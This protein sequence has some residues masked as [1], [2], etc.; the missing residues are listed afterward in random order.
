MS[1]PRPTTGQWKAIQD[2]KRHLTVSA[3]AGAGKTWVLTERYTA[4]LAGHP[5]IQPPLELAG[6]DALATGQA[7]S[8]PGQIVAITFTKEAAGEMKARIRERLSRWKFEAAQDD[9][10]RIALLQEEVERATITT[11]HGYCA[12]LL[13]QYP[14]EA[15]IDPQARV[16]EESEA[17]FRLEEA[18]REALDE[19]LSRQDVGVIQLVNEYSYEPLV[20][21]L[22][23]FYPSLRERTEDFTGMADLTLAKLTELSSGL[24]PAV[25]QLEALIHNVLALDLDAL[26]PSKG[27]VQRALHLRA[28]WPEISRVLST[29]RANHWDFSADIP[30][31]LEG[32]T[33]G[34]GPLVN[35]LKPDVNALKAHVP[36]VYGHIVPSGLR[37]TVVHLTALLQSV[38]ELY[39]G[40]KARDRALDFT[41]LQNLAVHLLQRPEV[42]RW[43]AA[44]LRFLMVDEFQD[45]NPVQKKL[46][47]ALTAD[48]DDLRLFVVG[49]AKQSIYRFRGADLDVFLQT[50]R[51][52]GD[53]GGE[54]VP[55][56]HNFRTQKPIISFV[57]RFFEL[58]MPSYEPMEA[59]RPPAH[60]QTMVEV[61]Q[62][63]EETGALPQKLREARTV[64]Q[65][66]R[67]MVGQERLVPDQDG[68]LRTVQYRDITLLFSAMTHVYVYEHAFQA[69]G[70]PYYI[71]GSR[72]FFRRQEIFDLVSV[73]HV[74]VEEH[75]AV[76]RIGALRS[77]LFGVSDEALYWLG[78]AGLVAT[79]WTALPNWH[80][81]AVDD[82]EK[83]A[84][85][86]ALF[87][88][89]REEKTY[90]SAAGV[91]TSILHH[92]GYEQ[93]LLL[94]FG[95]DQKV[96]NVRKLLELAQQ[97]PAE[98][99]S[100]LAFLQEL[101]KR[102]DGEVREEDAQVESD[103][104]DVVKI[105]T[106]HKSKGLEFPVVILPD[107]ARTFNLSEGGKF[108]YDPQLGLVPSF[109]ENEAWNQF[110]YSTHL[111]DQN[112][113]KALEEERRKLYV[114]MTRARDYLLLVGTRA[115]DKKKTPTFDD[116]RWFD[117][118]SA[119]EVENWP[120]VN[121]VRLT[122]EPEPVEDPLVALETGA[123]EAAATLDM[124]G[125]VAPL[126]E[127]FPLLGPIQ[128]RPDEAPDLTLSVSALLTYFTCPRQYYYKYA[129]RLPELARPLEDT[130]Q[131]SL[132]EDVEERRPSDSNLSATE[133]EDADAEHD[134]TVRGTLVHRVLELLRDPADLPALLRRALAERKIV[135]E[136][137]ERWI[138]LLEGDLQRF[139][140]SEL[141]QEVQMA[142]DQQSEM[143][144]RLRV[145]RHAVTGV[146]DKLYKKPNGRAVVLDYK[147][148]RITRQHLSRTAHHYTPQLQLYTLV[149][150]QL[151]GWSVERAVLYFTALDAEAEVPVTASDLQMMQSR[152][153][154][155]CDQI[156]M[157]EGEEGY[158]QTE[159][160]GETGETGVCG[161]C[162]YQLICR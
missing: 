29:W 82:R 115:L 162:P 121:W 88:L 59:T 4:M 104:S 91:L 96:G 150:E 116:S 99:G 62:I 137:A 151:L 83:L 148:N 100:V 126:E 7:P 136:E 40:K 42:R 54:H 67:E 87:R 144:F 101:Q 58:F 129:L 51:E 24:E 48:N 66:I 146:I 102:I 78:R 155:A 47:D 140:N 56:A 122:E 28:Q 134:P 160:T 73:M 46:L 64:A 72:N 10:R 6:Q 145:G 43:Q 23:D 106:V 142:T 92:T 39:R 98:R 49:D 5:L 44:S 86:Q 15:G 2:L 123:A 108:R 93:A 33:A 19:G 12:D 37:T 131:M 20:G 118:L 30:D 3:G 152:L 127:L 34:W 55:L 161:R 130:Q 74:L 53:V 128:P 113:Q 57:N 132:F 111:S 143:M 31:V 76:A 112:K 97:Q 117:W 65:R 109:T 85:A 139:A 90:K 84:R 41:D 11:I 103:Q 80:R 114:A 141:F 8:R 79:D 107:L 110:G 63:T 50:Q 81:L 68:T 35:A 52:V 138:P 60:D 13:R 14:I 16:L 125:E 147:T 36:T 75:D 45:T 153:Q 25:D 69:L 159:E 154:S 1:D 124:S 9:K 26:D 32:L 22:M 149:A 38:H 61:L 18:I 105:M 77:P 120:E 135:G 70:I 133:L 158:A 94:T 156:A 157:Q 17:V 71:V 21:H 119:A 27:S 95:G 89:W